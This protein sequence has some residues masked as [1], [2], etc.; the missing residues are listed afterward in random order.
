MGHEGGG[1]WSSGIP[2]SALGTHYCGESDVMDV[3]VPAPL[4]EVLLRITRNTQSTDGT[5][6]FSCL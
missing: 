3:T 2:I 4:W 1:D 6:G 5:W